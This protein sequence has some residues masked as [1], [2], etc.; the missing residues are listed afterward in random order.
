M[1]NMPL[2]PGENLARHGA[3]PVSLPKANSDLR[4]YECTPFFN[5]AW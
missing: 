3:C 2:G 5:G 4:V 1:M